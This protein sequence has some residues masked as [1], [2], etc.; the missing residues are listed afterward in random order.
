MALLLSAMAAGAA[1]R[2]ERFHAEIAVQEDGSLEVTETIAVRAEG[3]EI[4]RGI[5]REFPTRYRD[6]FGNRVQVGF[7]MLSAE[8]NGAAEPF[9]TERVSNGVEVFLGDDSFLEV[10]AT[11]TYVLRYRTT[12]QLG[13]F[14]EFD[15]LYWN[16]T[17]TGWIF[18]IDQASARVV[19]PAPVPAEELSAE[20]Y[21][22]PQGASGRDL[23]ARVTGPGEARYATTR[24]L[25]VREGMTIVLSFPKGVVAAPSA[26]TRAGWLLRDNLG[27]LVALAGLT[28]LLAFYLWQWNR[29]GRD[30]AAGVVFPRYQPPA[31][32]SPGG[33][34]YLRRMG[35]DT[36]CF[37]ADLV[38][39]AVQGALSIHRQ[40]PAAS[41]VLSGLFGSKEEWRLQREGGAP[42]LGH[43]QKALVHTLFRSS[44]SLLLRNTVPETVSTLQAA[45]SAHQSALK[46]AYQ[47]RFFSS[48]TGVV[49]AGAAWTVLVGMLAV[50][51]SGGSGMPA[52]VVLLLLAAAVNVV[53]L[54]LMRRPSAE[55]RRLLDEVEGLR[56][57]LGVAEKDDL[58][59]MQ[60]PGAE[61]PLDAERY[62]SLLPY[63][64]ALDVEDAWTTHFSRAADAAAQAEAQ[65]RTGRWY[66]GDL[67]RVSSLGQVGS[68][69]GNTLARQI[70]SSSSPPGSRSGSGGGGFSG[71]GGGGGGGRGR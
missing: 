67:A 45:R 43:A 7:D 10:P 33:L 52:M 29:K 63:A 69:L 20:G 37:T 53:F 22:G 31:D 21:T 51:A 60:G 71:G 26:A 38:D 36:S 3:Q 14:E 24:P 32:H 49:V 8:R 57:Y 15:E 65:A 70:A 23:E 35:W 5:I 41:G 28:S 54:V 12:R 13:F 64:M 58:S 59:R 39:A 66:R 61:P 4:R 27:V 56:L 17:G 16:V 68:A 25:Q 18:P 1:E 48:N 62:E 46:R 40:T 34:R 44:S 2:I 50:A 6:R 9:W 11:H 19:L 55:G 30:P 47:P 42:A